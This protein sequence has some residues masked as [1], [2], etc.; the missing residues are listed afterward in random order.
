M[1]IERGIKVGSQYRRY[2][3][4]IYDASAQPLVLVECKSFRRELQ[5]SDF[6]QILQY[7]DTVLAPLLILTNGLQMWCAEKPDYQFS[8]ISFSE[9]SK[10]LDS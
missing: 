10:K 2:D 3:L 8:E 9:L 6:A 1:A 7:N 5:S 4:M